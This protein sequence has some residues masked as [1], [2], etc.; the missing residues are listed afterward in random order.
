MAINKQ[1]DIAHF[2]Q[3]SLTIGIVLFY[4]LYLFS[5]TIYS[6]GSHADINAAGFD[7]VSNYT[8]DLFHTHGLNGV[9]NPA[10]PIGLVAVVLICTGIGYF[11]FQFSQLI[12]MPLFWKKGI[13]V[14]GT[15][16]M[17]CTILIFADLHHIMVLMASLFGL[18]ALIGVIRGLLKNKFYKYLWAGAACIL[19]LIGN[20][21]FYY[22]DIITAILPLI[23]KISIV[24]VLTWV[25]S[26]NFELVNI[27]ATTVTRLS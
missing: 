17:I 8:C 16:C 24:L 5:S 12:P 23:Q 22:F 2:Y 6:G 9:P 11:F 14:T 20:N 19:L 27:Q 13:Q 21:Y 1:N 10:R 15:L 18:L 4:G 3:Y 7:W 26:L 25:M